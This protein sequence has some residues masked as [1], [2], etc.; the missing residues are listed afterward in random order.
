MGGLRVYS[1][2]MSA[3][4][5]VI[6]AAAIIGFGMSGSRPSVRPRD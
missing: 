6:P 1:L 2:F 3:A 4:L 5:F